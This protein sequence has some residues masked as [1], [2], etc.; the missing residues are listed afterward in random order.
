MLVSVGRTFDSL[1]V[2]NYRLF[3]F[4]QILSWSGT[5]MQWVAQAWLILRLTDSGLA[6]GMVTALQWL[7]VLLFGAWA[8]VVADRFDKRRILLAT[9]VSSA[10]LS[11]ALGIATVAGFVDLWLVIAIAVVLGIVTAIDNPTRQTF[12]MELVG[13]DR[14][15]NAVSL[16]TATFTIARVAGPA[17]AGLLIAWVDVG[18]VFVI[19]A[20]SFVPVTLGLLAMRQDELR[21]TPRA[22][23]A[24]GQVREGLRYA[25]STPILRTLL[26]VMAVVGTLQYNFH[27]LI[28]LLAKNTFGGDAREF[29]LL[30]AVLG[31]GML[32]G[33]LASAAVGRNGRRLLV[34]AG[35][36]LGLCS[37]LV[38]A[39]PNIY[40][41]G[42]IMV[43]LGMASMLFLTTMN[44]TL[45]LNSSDE[46]RGRVMALYFVLFLGSTPIGAPIIGWVAEAFD[47]RAALALGGVATLGAMTYAAV[48]LLRRSPAPAAERM[49][50][51]G[52]DHDDI[53]AVETDPIDE[54]EPVPTADRL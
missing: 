23:R 38:A 43:P 28:S 24:R 51:S 22:Q 36:A 33:S 12:T 8:G 10:V 40:V 14:L 20:L 42:A 1:R 29:G 25:S 11:L 17:I 46:M 5:W 2:R 16:N 3:F 27:I 19:N 15:A 54:R 4:G 35:T 6:L 49:V 31:G 7:P 21:P 41:A 26:T 48:K 47:P 32:L 18:P 37:L 53:E 45:Q 39:A 30:G 9:N 34:G 13:R 44:S 52:D 50:V